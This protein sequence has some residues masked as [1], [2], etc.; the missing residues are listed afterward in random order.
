VSK[1]VPLLREGANELETLLLEAAREDASPDPTA[2]ARTLAALRLA[3]GTAVA[4]AGSGAAG[5]SARLLLK[6]A[7]AKWYAIGALGGAV[8]LGGAEVVSRFVAAPSARDR[9]AVS[10]VASP[11]VSAPRAAPAV[12]AAPVAAPTASARAEASAIPSS[13]RSPPAAPPSLVTPPIAPPAAEGRSE[14]P[15]APSLPAVAAQGS[16]VAPAPSASPPPKSLRDEAALLESVREA[17]AASQPSRAS[18]AL[19]TY[20]ADFPSGILAQEAA[21]LR[22]EALLAAGDLPAARRAADAFEKRHPQSSYL[23]RVRELVRKNP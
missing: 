15:R 8:A 20:D 23:P 17:L 13:R 12:A 16:T 2:R 3:S 21:V 9:G 10:P 1:L 11:P 14:T 18:A 5:W 22:V 4:A 7:P 6:L 19:D